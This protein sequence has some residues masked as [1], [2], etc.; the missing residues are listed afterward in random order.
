MKRNYVHYLFSLS[1]F[2]LVSNC[3]GQITF[4][5]IIDG[6]FSSN[7]NSVQETFDGGYI[8]T[9]DMIDSMGSNIHSFLVKT[10]NKGVVEWHKTFN[11]FVGTR[12]NAVIQTSEGGYIMAGLGWKPGNYNSDFLVIKTNAL[13]DTEWTRFYGDSI[14]EYANSIRQTLDGGYIIIGSTDSFRE[15]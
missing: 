14:V 4:Q 6:Q 15:Y 11:G 12:I 5:R 10:D 1:L 8:L 9:G 2:L 13:G 3:F 7:A